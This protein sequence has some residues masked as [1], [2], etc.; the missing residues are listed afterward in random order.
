MAARR[1][2]P[3]RAKAARSGHTPARRAALAKPTAPEPPAIRPPATAAQ[4][5]ATRELFWQNVMREI[6]TN[7]SMVS[8]QQR[9]AQ[10]AAP[11]ASPPS[12]PALST[13]AAEAGGEENAEQMELFDGRL[14]VITRQGQ[15]VPIAAVSPMF[16]C[17][18]A[19]P[20][21][22]TLSMEVECTVFQIRTPGGEVFT[23]PLHEM[24]TFHA[25]TPGLMRQLEEAATREAKRR[26][27]S[28]EEEGAPFGFAA[29]TS[30]ARGGP[31]I[32]PMAP[33]DPSE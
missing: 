1:K 29:F 21:E 9:A 31:S 19:T 27:G 15:R 4:V 11:G 16:A 20:G 26:G 33:I 23:L 5:A 25:L 8:A 30:L 13:E 10:P 7:L 32:I 6:L 24:R 17:G 18:I 2:K 28:P 12:V 3:G 22:R 14:A